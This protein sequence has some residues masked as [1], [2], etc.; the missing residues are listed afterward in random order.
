MATITK[1]I[2]AITLLSLTGCFENVIPDPILPDI[3]KYTEIGANVSG[4]YL[5]NRP[6]IANDESFFKCI[7]GCSDIIR[8]EKKES[9]NWELY[10]NGKYG[11]DLVP[12]RIVFYQ[13]DFGS[14][15]VFSLEGEKI[16]LGKEHKFYSGLESC[17]TENDGVGQFYIR[18]VKR[19][20]N[21]NQYIISGT[22]SF[23]LNQQSTCQKDFTYGRYDILYNPNP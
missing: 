14:S 18:S 3:P 13:L 11:E 23:K 5:N 15:S 22:F 19:D 8:L 4:A 2:L 16:V 12:V 6:W 21:S 9:G 7:L 1:L 10:M 20:T 17:E